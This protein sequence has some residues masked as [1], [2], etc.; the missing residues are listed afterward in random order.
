MARVWQH[1]QHAI[2]PAVTLLELHSPTQRL[3][4]GWMDLGL[5][6][7]APAATTDQPVPGS[8]V[9]GGGEWHLGRPTEGWV[10]RSAKPR[11]EPNVA[12]IPKWLAAR[13]P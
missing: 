9:T 5:R 1:Q 10:K 4:V 13:S 11:K 2:D 7:V 12:S 8:L 3:R 6:S